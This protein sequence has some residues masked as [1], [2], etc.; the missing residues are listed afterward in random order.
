M[1][2]AKP[3]TIGY[4]LQSSCPHSASMPPNQSWIPTLYVERIEYR[5]G[6]DEQR[7]TFFCLF[8]PFKP[9]TQPRRT[10]GTAC[11]SNEKKSELSKGRKEPDSVQ[12]ENINL[13]GSS[14]GSCCCC[15]GAYHT[16]TSVISITPLHCLLSLLWVKVGVLLVM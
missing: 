9:T 2:G 5:R 12:S 16:E 11:S 15:V 7:D 6:D 3:T 8:Y 4:L 13:V 10:E 14:S 1:P